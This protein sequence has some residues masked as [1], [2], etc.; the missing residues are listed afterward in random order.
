MVLLLL[1]SG[2]SKIIVVKVPQ[3]SAPPTSD[4]V[5][6]ALPK[7][8]VRVQLK[9]D[10]TTR[11]AAPFATYAAIFAP[12]LSPVCESSD[13]G[14]KGVEYSVEDGAVF[15][16][17]GEPDPDQVFL[18]KFSDSGAIDQSLTM[19]WNDAG[20]F[21][22]ASS[23]VTNRTTDIITSSIGMATTLAAKTFYG[24]PVGGAGAKLTSC[25]EVLKGSGSAPA[26]DKTVL[27]AIQGASLGDDTIQNTLMVNYCR[28]KA[29]DRTKLDLSNFNDALAAYAKTVAPLAKQ[30]NSLLLSNGG[31]FDPTPLIARIETEINTHL[32]PL[33]I[34]T[35]TQTTWTATLDTRQ[36]AD[37]GS[38]KIPSIPL[39]H[40]GSNGVEVRAE[41]PPEGTPEP[42]DFKK[43]STQDDKDFNLQLAYY[44]AKAN[45]MF[46]RITD[47]TSGNRSFRYRV[48]AQLRVSLN[49]AEKSY[50]GATLS[51]AQLGTVVSLPASRHSKSLTY[52]LGLAEATGALKTF[53]LGTV[54]SLDAATITSLSTSAGGLLDARNT[55]AQTAATAAPSALTKQDTILKLQ[56][57]ICTI[58]QKYN[59]PCTVQPQ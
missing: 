35:K 9:V 37:D 13:C 49:D 55:A 53:T 19:T 31:V 18:V 29:E 11:K 47:S 50:G 24:A 41:V 52:N 5:I 21:S 2:C 59:L 51:V 42:A 26:N 10:K 45:Q 39:L 56:D 32:I 27:T 43:K 1:L 44:P 36:I 16:T 48:P 17:Y 8:V 33:F 20:L 22:S 58:Q 6:Y 12:D 54:G 23:T 15:T 40:F 25:D 7:T 4:G 57:D 34:G 46:T 28:I 38:G 14:K 30:R 3:G